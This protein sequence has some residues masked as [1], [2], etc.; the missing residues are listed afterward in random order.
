MV[1]RFTH[2]YK[3][4]TSTKLKSGAIYGILT[5]LRR[6][7]LANK[8]TSNITRVVFVIDA[9]I[10]EF[11]FKLYPQYKEKR[12]LKR[13][14]G[15][16]PFYITYQNEL[17]TVK[18]N[19]SHLGVIVLKVDGFEGDDTICKVVN[20]LSGHKFVYSND[21]DMQ[22][23]ISPSVT[24]CVPTSIKGVCED[25]MTEKD[26]FYLIRRAI[27]GD[28]SDEIKGVPGLGKVRTDE[29]LQQINETK[30]KDFFANTHKSKQHA[31]LQKGRAI[32]KRNIKLMSLKWAYKHHTKKA[33]GQYAANQFTMKK[34][35]K[36]CKRFELKSLR[37]EVSE[38]QMLLGDMK[39][40][41]P[42]KQYQ[43]L[44]YL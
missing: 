42:H 4:H 7:L 15:N 5:F 38:F 21:H 25:F 27:C 6:F 13:K 19:L 32:I 10:P 26:P 39:L 8:A 31:K 20:D 44:T 9:G 11:R 1:S 35:V 23:L 12:W 36:L 22:Q 37:P 43:K 29:L 2:A 28:T 34:F 17:H 33:V 3:L 16:D 24:A 30:L 41:L 40:T 14:T 18:E